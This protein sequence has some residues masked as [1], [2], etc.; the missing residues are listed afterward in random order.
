MYSIRVARKED[1]EELIQLAKLSPVKGTISLMIDRQPDYFA[2]AEER[3]ESITLVTVNS[4]NGPAGD[5]HLALF[6]E[7]G[8][9]C[10]YDVPAGV[11]VFAGE[12]SGSPETNSNCAGARLPAAV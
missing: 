6:A 10:S 2:L 7:N 8:R 1:N 3:G 5:F 11:C 4:E 12:G 9:A